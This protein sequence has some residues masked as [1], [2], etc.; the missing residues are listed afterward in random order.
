M[1]QYPPP[2]L[3]HPIVPQHQHQQH[4]SPTPASSQIGLVTSPPSNFTPRKEFLRD[5]RTVASAFSLFTLAG[6][7]LVRL[8]S[9]HAML[10][11]S[12]RRLF[13]QHDLVLD[14]REDQEKRFHE[15]MLGDKPWAN[16]KSIKAEKLIVDILTVILHS[17]YA[18]LSTIDY[19]RESDDKLAVAFSRPVLQPA[20]MNSPAYA[21]MNGSALSLNQ[22]PR[23]PFAIS[24][25]SSTSLRVVGPPLHS[26]PAIL[27]AVRGAWPRGVVSDRKVGD[28]TFEFKLKGYKWFQEDTFPM[29]SLNHILGLL[30]ALDG[31]GF[32]LLT[33]L[34]FTKPSRVKDLWIFT[35]ISDDQSPPITPTTSM[36]DPKRDM[37]P[38]SIIPGPSP[39]SA[40]SERR[41]INRLVSPVVTPPNGN[42]HSNGHVR[43][44]SENTPPVSTSPPKLPGLPFG[45]LPTT[46]LRKPSPK[47]KMPSAFSSAKLNRSNSSGPR[48]SR[49]TTPTADRQGAPL[50]QMMRSLSNPSSVGSV[51]MTGVGR[52]SVSLSKTP[53]VFYVSDGR[54][55]GTPPQEYNPFNAALKPNSQTPHAA[56]IKVT[57]PTQ[58]RRASMDSKSP[59]ANEGRTLTRP[60]V[61]RSSTIPALDARQN[62]NTSTSGQLLSPP[63]INVKA[64]GGSNHTLNGAARPKREGKEPPAALSLN[65]RRRTPTPP[66]LTPGTFRDSAFSWATG[67]TQDVPIT[68]SGR[69]PEPIQ[70]ADRQVNVVHDAGAGEAHRKPT[71]HPG[72]NGRPE[73]DRSPSVPMPPGGWVPSPAP[74]EE[75]GDVSQQSFKVLPSTIREQP[76]QEGDERN[77]AMSKSAKHVFARGRER[78]REPEARA[79]EREAEDVTGGVVAPHVPRMSGMTAATGSTNGIAAP[80]PKAGRRETAMSGWVMVNVEGAASG[81]AQAPSARQSKSSS[82][83]PPGSRPAVR[84]RRSN[85]DS[86]LI[87]P[88]QTSNSPVGNAPAQ[89]TMSAAAKQIAMIDALEVKKEEQ[90][91]ANSPSG[92][93]RM[94][95]RTKGSESDGSGKASALRRKT[96]PESS[97][98]GN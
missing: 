32:T 69:D 61:R 35:G 18:F 40:G 8:Y 39:L 3:K 94:F 4:V 33:S 66:L 10:I 83:S 15:F 91:K 58:D 92:F 20:G 37:P 43:S 34:S 84:H 89:T 30:S 22:P 85:S 60:T 42:G 67:K 64:S 46:L 17:G 75:K 77:R 90:E 82:Q 48:L 59:Y 93:K 2:Q 63:P 31:H 19:G 27:T 13:N 72:A 78:E 96:T 1:A 53:D 36:F 81:S 88:A 98:K 79:T 44:A 71:L 86:G 50:N 24:F 65:D 51:D 9:F 55:K 41:S 23:T 62:S 45:S 7:N 95:H 28:A 49:P 11:N 5:Q 80:K 74:R 68:W 76:G 21:A 12:L 57:T 54:G 38:H 73:M 87:R 70:G 52:R 47:S 14:E 29:D 25:S 56:F 97:S 26:T 6:S 16:P